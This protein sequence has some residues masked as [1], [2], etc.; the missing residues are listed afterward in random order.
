V[1]PP[2]A[3]APWE[4]WVP[5]GGMSRT[6]LAVAAALH[7]LADLLEI[8]G[9][10]R[11]RTLAYRRA[12]DAVRGLGRDVASM[13]DAELAGVHGLGK[14]TAGK[15]RELVATG[16]MQVLEDLRAKYPTGVLEMTRVSG[17][18]PKKA[19]ALHAALGVETLEELEEALRAGRLRDVKG[20]GARTEENLLRAL[21]RHRMQGGEERRILLGEALAVAEEMLE[22]VRTLPGI[23]RASYAGSL[24]RMRDTIGDLD[25]LVSSARPQEAVEA[26]G[27]L[28]NV[29][30]VLGRG[31]TKTGVLTRSGLQIDLRVVAPGEFGSA[32]QYFTGSKAH[33][34]KV[35]EHAVR[36]GLKLSEYGLFRAGE[37]IA[38][39]TEEEVYEALGMQTP[40]APM[41]EDRGEVE[42]A[43]RG[44]LPALVELADL[45][46]DLQSHSVYSDG[47]RTIREMA[48]A[49]AAKGYEYFAV[50]DHGRNLP[51]VRNL[52]LDDIVRQRV[53]I[54]ALNEEL[55]GRIVVLHGLEANIG[56][57]GELDYPDEI[58]A[59]F[60]IVV[61]SL[62]HQLRGDRA[63]MTRRVLRAIEHPHVHVLGHPTGRMLPRRPASDL[64]MEAVCRAALAHGVALEINANPR[65][66]DL[67]DDHAFLAR[68]MGCLFA[69]STDAHSPRELDLMRFGVATAQR[70]W[71]ESRDVVNTWLLDK[72][73]RFLAKSPVDR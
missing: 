49:A 66:L 14:A 4:W 53:E 73:R 37:R 52:S 60:D 29:G 25:L 71:V 38:G 20:F 58:M 43:L 23:E 50:T 35:R 69:I 48:L 57:E 21:E 72:L 65:R 39:A 67:K 47:R 10:D 70:G 59:G 7:E 9:G 17:L 63:A 2:G 41:R 27:A 68:E 45:R 22:G 5:F 40:P 44:A 46:G 30:R 15:V 34:V 64:D 36:M 61:A 51:V 55:A 32:L 19:V 6:N 13:T 1:V 54:K 3:S 33:N 24:R 18:G 8:N 12:G 31:P 11:F 26:F 28:P 16:S 62:H 42:L 56:M